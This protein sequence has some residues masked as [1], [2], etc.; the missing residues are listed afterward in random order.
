MWYLRKTENGE[1]ESHIC[2]T[3]PK[4][5]SAQPEKVPKK[6]CAYGFFGSA[7]KYQGNHLLAIFGLKIE[8]IQKFQFLVVFATLWPIDA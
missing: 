2:F 8:E 6:W 1:T 3:S 5:P 7:I 4:V